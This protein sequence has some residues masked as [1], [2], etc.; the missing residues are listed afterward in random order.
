MDD[1]AADLARLGRAAVGAASALAAIR[2]SPFAPSILAGLSGMAGLA[3][4]R[5]ARDVERARRAALGVPDAWRGTADQW[6]AMNGPTPAEILAG[7]DRLE[8]GLRAAASA[9]GDDVDLAA[10]TR[11]LRGE[12]PP[13]NRRARR[14]AAKR[15]G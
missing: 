2:D 10:L 11:R 15:K 5:E 6:L 7:A 12:L 4:E 8:A 9:P 1:P 13:P 14:R 3:A